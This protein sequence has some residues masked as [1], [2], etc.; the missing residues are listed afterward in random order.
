MIIGIRDA[1]E[2]ASNAGDAESSADRAMFNP[3]TD[4]ALRYREQRALQIIKRFCEHLSPETTVEDILDSIED[5]G[6]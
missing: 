5:L 1:M 4:R 2:L 3:P 6:Q